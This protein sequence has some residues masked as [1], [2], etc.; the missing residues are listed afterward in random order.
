MVTFEYNEADETI[1][2]LYNGK[3]VSIFKGDSKEERA[4]WV[5]RCKSR[6]WTEADEIAGTNIFLGESLPKSNQVFL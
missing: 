3:L 1:E 5:E 4:S 6:S 2:C